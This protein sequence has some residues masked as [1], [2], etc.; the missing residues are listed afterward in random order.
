MDFISYLCRQ[1]VCH[2]KQRKTMKKV[3]FIL[4]AMLLMEVAPSGA[5]GLSFGLKGGINTTDMNFDNHILDANY[6]C[7][8]FIGPAVR[9][10]LPITSLGV[11]I[12]G[13]YEQREVGLNGSVVRQESVVVPVNLRLDFGVSDNLGI[14]LALGPQFGFNVGNDEFDLRDKE[15][16]N[17]TFQ[18]KKSAFS[19][20]LGAG[21]FLSKYL[22]VGLSYNIAMGKTGDASFKQAIKT[23]TN[24][25]TYSDD[26]Y[27]KTWALSAAIYF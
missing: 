21:V 16:V 5:R 10:D 4:V 2:E 24:E 25:E 12:A 20:N 14:Y 17:S 27:A 18:L 7:G 26:S 8:W 3:L 23:V 6:R 15:I 11:D 13:L 19:L 1:I 22:E 9:I